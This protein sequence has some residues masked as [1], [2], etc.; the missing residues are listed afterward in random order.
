MAES[1]M[2]LISDF[3][4]HFE[5]VYWEVCEEDPSLIVSEIVRMNDM[6]FDERATSAIEWMNE[7]PGGAELAKAVKEI[8]HSSPGEDRLRFG[9]H[10]DCL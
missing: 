2:S 6:K 10:T 8:K 1:S 5:R 7:K 9:V 4:I 3:K